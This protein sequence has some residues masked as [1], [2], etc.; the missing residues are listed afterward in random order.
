MSL[1]LDASVIV[2]LFIPEPK[3]KAMA[4][5]LGDLDGLPCVSNFGAGEVPSAKSRQVWMKTH[6]KR[7]LG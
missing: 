7:M 4:D 5:A 6:S 3:S 2:P 1:Y